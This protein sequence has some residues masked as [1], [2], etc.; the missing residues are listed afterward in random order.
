VIVG[1]VAGVGTTGAEVALGILD[2]DPRMPAGAPVCANAKEAIAAK[3]DST[4]HRRNAR[5]IFMA[6]RPVFLISTL[7]LPA[8]SRSSTSRLSHADPTMLGAFE[9][10][11]FYSVAVRARLR[12]F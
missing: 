9:G 7:P 8:D 11:F 10:C 6:G 12:E 4:A 2:G 1:V 3:Q 5:K